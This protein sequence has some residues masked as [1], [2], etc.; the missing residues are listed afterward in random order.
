MAIDDWLDMMPHTV[1]LAE[2]SNRDEYG[3]MS[4]GSEADYR[5]RV[6]YK[7]VLVRGP[8][9]A[10]VIARGWVWINGTPDMIPEDK[11]ILPDNTEPPILYVERI[12]D[13]EGDHH[14]KIYFG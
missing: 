5:A 7:N 2:F 12:A 4:Y 9:G 8:D 11:L 14:I 1:T 10:E 13:E 3:V 6:T